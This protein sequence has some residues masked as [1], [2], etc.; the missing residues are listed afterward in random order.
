MKIQKFNSPVS[1]SIAHN[2]GSMGPRKT[3]I[4]ILCLSRFYF[5]FLSI[6]ICFETGWVSIF[7][8][9]L[10]NWEIRAEGNINLSSTLT[11]SPVFLFLI[12]FFLISYF[13]F[14]YFLFL[15]FLFLISAK[16]GNPSRGE[17]KPVS[18]TLTFSPVFLFWHFT[19]QERNKTPE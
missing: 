19:K 8:R 13:F 17:Y 3:F 15:F 2:P 7:R 11:F 9:W 18:S 5:Y 4:Y 6:W 14:S 1:K 16:L 10:Q 12:S